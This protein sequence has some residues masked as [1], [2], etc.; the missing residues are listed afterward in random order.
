M[1]ITIIQGHPDGHS[2]HLCH[3]LADEYAD[4][5]RS[6]GHSVRLIDLG[7][8]EFPLLR[9]K[10]AFEHAVLPPELATAQ[11]DLAWANHLV[12]VYPLWLGEMPAVVKG[13]FEQVLRPGFAF[14][15]AGHGWTS[16]LTGKTARV[17]VTMGMPAAV[18]RWYFGAHSLK[19]LRRNV[20]SFVGI[21]P[22]RATLIGLVES[23]SARRR[24][25]WLAALRKLG[26]AAR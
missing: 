22:V 15:V 8:L 21:K 11:G 6:A 4:G 20:L 18:Y 25:S 14:D 24:Q 7:K 17:V 12:L 13:F 3:A 2:R 19:S 5:A 23:A 9:T 26:A 16:K 1:N 10:E